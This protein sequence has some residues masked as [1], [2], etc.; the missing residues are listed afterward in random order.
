MSKIRRKTAET[1]VVVSLR[2]GDGKAAVQTTDPF[3]DHML[4]TLARTSGLD[5]EVK[6]QGDLRHHLIEDVAITLGLAFEETIPDTCRRF[7]HAVVPMDDALVE[8]TLDAGGR[9]YYQGPLPRPM[10]DHFLRSLADAGGLTLHVRVLRGEDRHHV[11]EAAFKALGLALRQVIVPA[12]TLC[13]TKG[14]VQIERLE[15]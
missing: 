15:D 11:V 14:A 7:G 1:E 4:E 8:V 9:R 6:A 3:L 10:F 2:S 12:A 13:S 5:L